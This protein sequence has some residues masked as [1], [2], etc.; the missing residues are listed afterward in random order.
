MS[1]VRTRQEGSAITHSW[2][3]CWGA[4]GFLKEQ[5]LVDAYLDINAHRG[6]ITVS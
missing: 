5:M 3:P 2:L 4:T 6:T 1:G